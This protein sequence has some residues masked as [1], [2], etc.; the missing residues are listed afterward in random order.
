MIGAGAAGLTCAETLANAG[1]TVTVFEK[2]GDIGGRLASRRRGD[3]HWNHGAPAADLTS[4]AAREIGQ[5]LIANDSATR[6]QNRYLGVP[7]MRELLRPL[8]PS[9]GVQFQTTVTRIVQEA[10]GWTLL[11][12]E[13]GAE[14]QPIPGIFSQIVCTAPAPQARLLLERSDIPVPAELDTVA[15]SP[16]WALLITLPT[17][18]AVGAMDCGNGAELA[19]VHPGNWLREQTS[20]WVAHAST[21]WTEQALEWSPEQVVTSLQG[22]LQETLARSGY[23]QTPITVKA[24]RWRFARTSQPL[25]EPC[26]RLPHLPLVLAGDWC[27]GP[28]ADAAMASGLAAAQS[29][30]GNP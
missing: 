4:A 20:T 16:C 3:Q 19:S 28:N 21:Q 22:P 29:L 17:N 23:A 26:L 1:R 2:S 7:D 11:G 18:L 9:K 5:R 27:L 30:L 6:L 15:V 14:A 12:Q 24:H 25:G 8:A 10:G 13:P